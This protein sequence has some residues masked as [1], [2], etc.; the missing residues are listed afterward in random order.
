MTKLT[1]TT[2][3]ELEHPFYRWRNW[4]SKVVMELTPQITQLAYTW[5]PLS[6]PHI[7][8]GSRVSYGRRWFPVS[9]TFLLLSRIKSS[10]HIQSAHV[11]GKKELDK[12]ARISI[13]CMLWRLFSLSSHGRVLQLLLKLLKDMGTSGK[14]TWVQI[15]PPA[16]ICNLI[17]GV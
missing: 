8:A 14:E 11:M 6:Q 2:T 15:L 9:L 13:N 10:R 5:V 16:L 17:L 1:F 3:Q 4:V 7:R 12:A